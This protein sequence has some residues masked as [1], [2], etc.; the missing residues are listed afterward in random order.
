MSEEGFDLSGWEKWQTLE[1]VPE[2]MATEIRDSIVLQLEQCE[3]TVT[4]N[5]RRFPEFADQQLAFA[6]VYSIFAKA[7]RAGR[8]K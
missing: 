2:E 3:Q 8:L 5:A 6:R 1:D 7:A 4:D